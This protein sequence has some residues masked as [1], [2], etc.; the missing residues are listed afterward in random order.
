MFGQLEEFRLW[1]RYGGESHVTGPR[2]QTGIQ[3][4]TELMQCPHDVFYRLNA[5]VNSLAE[6]VMHINEIHVY[7]F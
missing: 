3:H 4:V 2:H 6:I 5:M 1:Q 7:Y